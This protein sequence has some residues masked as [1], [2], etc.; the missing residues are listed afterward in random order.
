MFFLSNLLC[1]FCTMYRSDWLKNFTKVALDVKPRYLHLRLWAQF[2]C[3]PSC[4]LHSS[5]SLLSG[6]SIQ[7]GWLLQSWSARSISVTDVYNHMGEKHRDTSDYL[8]HR[9]NPKDK[10]IW[11]TLIIRPALIFCLLSLAMLSS[12]RTK[13][14]AV[15]LGEQV[16][17]GMGKS[18]S[19]LMTWAAQLDDRFWQVLKIIIVATGPCYNKIVSI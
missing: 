10:P 1:C 7:H 17:G 5:N 11:V 9:P 16:R 2:C 8:Y 18:L 13:T 14:P 6:F 19:L 12:H 4:L 3:A 15:C